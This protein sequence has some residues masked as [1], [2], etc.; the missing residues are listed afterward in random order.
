MRPTLLEKLYS[1]AGAKAMLVL[2]PLFTLTGLPA[3]VVPVEAEA[4][5]IVLHQ[6]QSQHPTLV[7]P[8]FDAI[9]QSAASP[10]LACP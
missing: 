10:G 5:G 4:G 8:I 1:I 7:Q 3:T 6:I 2:L 9:P